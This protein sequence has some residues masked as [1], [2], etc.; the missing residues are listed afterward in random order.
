[1]SIYDEFGARV[2]TA[3]ALAGQPSPSVGTRLRH[4]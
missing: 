3:W 1:M 4:R 2:P